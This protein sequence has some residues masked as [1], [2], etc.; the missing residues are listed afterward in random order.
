M[1]T[2]IENPFE[3]LVQVSYPHYTTDSSNSNKTSS[4]LGWIFGI[5]LIVGSV[6]IFFVWKESKELEEQ[7][8]GELEKGKDGLNKKDENV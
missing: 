8:K 3:E 7:K 1:F 5:L 4:I 6:I 2:Q